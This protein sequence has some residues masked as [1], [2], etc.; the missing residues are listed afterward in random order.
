MA[1]TIFSNKYMDNLNWLNM[2]ALSNTPLTSY[3]LIDDKIGVWYDYIE[4]HKD[5]WRY[6][7][8]WTCKMW[9]VWIVLK[10]LLDLVAE[11]VKSARDSNI[12][13]ISNT[14]DKGKMIVSHN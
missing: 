3:Y 12:M 10:L 1:I 6:R 2:K 11:K 8:Y 14:K 9:V 4:N 7:T 13:S 5:I